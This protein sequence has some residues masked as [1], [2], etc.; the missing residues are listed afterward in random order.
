M[1]KGILSYNEPQTSQSTRA[2]LTPNGADES[3]V[4]DRI[5][6]NFDWWKENQHKFHNLRRLS[7]LYKRIY[8]E[9]ET[10]F[11]C[12]KILYSSHKFVPEE[13]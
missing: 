6:N 7:I 13:P 11:I 12:A 9:G 5:T 2:R 3:D 10:V 8:S 1:S 4:A